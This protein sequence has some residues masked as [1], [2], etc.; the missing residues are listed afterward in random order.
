MFDLT[1]DTFGTGNVKYYRQTIYAESEV[2]DNMQIIIEH[3][4][5]QFYLL[6]S[7]SGISIV[8]FIKTD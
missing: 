8:K 7:E 2:S 5:S 6:E 1:N 3:L 4:D